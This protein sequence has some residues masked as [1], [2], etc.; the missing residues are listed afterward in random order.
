MSKDI[1]SKKTRHEFREHFVGWTLREIREEFDSADV[2]ADEDYIPTLPGQ[3]RSLVEKYYHGVDWTKWEDVRKVLAVFRN[4]LVQLE[5]ASKNTETQFSEYARKTFNSLTKWLKL[6]GFE[7][8]DGKLE[9][10]GRGRQLEALSAT[11][12]KFDTPELQ[13]QIERLYDSIEDD[14]A[15][16]IGTAKELVETACKTILTERGKKVDEAWDLGE[17]VKE[18]R[19]ALGLLPEDVPEAAKG[20]V[21]VRK[22]LGSLGNIAQGLGELRN[23]YGTGHGKH[24]RAKG[25]GQR[26]ARLAVGA[27]ATLATFL[28]ETHVERDAGK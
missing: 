14:P 23:L 18:T 16:A 25:L 7:Y 4:V 2:L 26:H 19:K 22:L 27:A 21:T 20:A 10:V 5:I 24:G 15:L 28:F 11:T 13:R 9:A 3:R 1:I 12:A 6:D 17:L 8:A